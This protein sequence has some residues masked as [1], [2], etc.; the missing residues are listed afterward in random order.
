[1][2][3]PSFGGQRSALAALVLRDQQGLV[4]AVCALVELVVR[5]S[6]WS[7]PV[8]AHGQK[9]LSAVIV[10]FCLYLWGRWCLRCRRCLTPPSSGH[11]PAGRVMPL[12]SNVSRHKE[13]PLRYIIK[14]PLLAFF[15][16]SGA[17][18]YAQPT[19]ARALVEAGAAAYVKEGASA[20]VQVWV[21]GSALQGNTQALSQANSL[22]QIEDF[23]GK[24]IGFEIITDNPIGSRSRMVLF[25]INYQKGALFARFQAYQ[26]DGG[27]W[28]TTEFKFQTEAA[29]VFPPQL[30]FGR[31]G[32]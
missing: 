22:R 4:V 5:A 29:N 8:G 9:R 16:L 23:F 11:A 30:V 15:L 2:G 25:V 31:S 32:G 6:S 14:L 26:V 24:P 19:T 28:V 17:M 1:V 7:G 27:R 10:Q 12:M 3:C 13:L 18:S 20:A 21:E